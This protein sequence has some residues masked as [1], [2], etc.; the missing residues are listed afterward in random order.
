MPNLMWT[1]QEATVIAGV[2]AVGWGALLR[3][4]AF[5]RAQPFLREAALII[6]LY[7][8]WQFAG[9]LSGNG[10]YAAV[11]RGRWIW[12]SER[13]AHLL[14]ER[15]VQDWVLPHPLIVQ[16]TNL[17][18]DTM[19]FS[20]MIVFLL[21]LF[22]RHRD[23][24]SRWRTTLALLTASCLLIQLMPVAPPRMIPD[25]GMVDTAMKYGQSV[26]GSVAGFRADQLSAMPSVHVGWAA[27]VAVCVY[28]VS[29]S[30]WRYVGVAHA[31]MTVFVVVATGNHYWDDGIVAVA[32][33]IAALLMQWTA[34]RLWQQRVTARK[35]LTK[36][37][38]ERGGLVDVR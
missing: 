14:N 21:W 9:S 6:G 5:P 30:R 3:R 1:W 38:A 29:P 19:H 18:Y 10:T 27:L 16:A 31:A 24:Y 34:R 26:Y 33:L 32:L 28:R 2:L 22:A 15:T 4:R 13:S 35:D 17:Y 25:L 20:V 11:G 12:N 8:L 7:A 36:Q 37:D 23:A